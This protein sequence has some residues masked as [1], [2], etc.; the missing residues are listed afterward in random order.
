MGQ[1]KLVNV[2]N[3][4]A[5]RVLYDTSLKVALS[6]LPIRRWGQSP[7]LQRVLSEK[8]SWDPV[9]PYATFRNEYLTKCCLDLGLKDANAVVPPYVLDYVCTTMED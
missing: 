6:N 7:L 1:P 8:S 5:S 2:K 3:I 4:E 9:V